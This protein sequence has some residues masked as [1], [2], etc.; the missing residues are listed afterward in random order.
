MRKKPR[1]RHMSM[2]DLQ[3]DI[4]GIS[5]YSARQL[6]PLFEHDVTILDLLFN[7]GPD[8]TKYM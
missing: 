3:I 2:S 5:V 6:F 8:A 7:E 4:I 1:S